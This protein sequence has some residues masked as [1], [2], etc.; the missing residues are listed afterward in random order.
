MARLPRIGLVIGVAIAAGG[1]GSATTV[2][3]S[4]TSAQQSTT[5]SAAANGSFTMTPSSS[6]TQ[7]T[8]YLYG[9]TAQITFSSDTLD[10]TPACQTWAR[11][12]GAQGEYWVIVQNAGQA[13]SASDAVTVCSMENAQG[14]VFAVVNDSRGQTYGQ[15]ACSA[16]VS[17][18]W[19][20]SNAPGSPGVTTQTEMTTTDRNGVECD[21]SLL[22]P[23][24][25]CQ[26]P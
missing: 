2:T 23:D 4:G 8:V 1:C 16:L 5:S 13:P 21:T 24:G 18:G 15:G 9:H 17:D 11:T 3:V 22:G 7:C 25:L 14:T 19:V 12:S 26:R 10:V 20:Q 6:S